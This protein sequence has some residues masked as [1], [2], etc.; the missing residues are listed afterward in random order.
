IIGRRSATAPKKFGQAVYD[1]MKFNMMGLQEIYNTIESEVKELVKNDNI[2]IGEANLIAAVGS[3]DSLI[4]T[5]DV[6]FLEA[7]GSCAGCETTIERIR[8][9]IVCFE[10]C[11][12]VVM[13]K[14]GFQYV[15]EHIVPVLNVDHRLRVFFGQGMQSSETNAMA[16]LMSYIDYTVKV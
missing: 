15:L 3:S 13:Q 2:P 1:R 7:L 8:G 11:I 10:Q 14:F 5:A 16:G 12:Y 9:R 4:L 6:R